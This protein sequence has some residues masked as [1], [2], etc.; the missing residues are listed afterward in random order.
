MSDPETMEQLIAGGNENEFMLGSALGKR[1]ADEMN[2]FVEL[3][4]K[5]G[6]KPQ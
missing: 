5:A 3:A 2:L 4:Q 6:I 1:V